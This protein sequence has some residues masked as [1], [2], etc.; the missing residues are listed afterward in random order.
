MRD[1]SASDA[2]VR[3]AWRGKY[4]AF[5]EP[6][7][8]GMKHLRA[9][10]RAGLTDVHLLPVFDFASVPERDCKQPAVPKA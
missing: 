8:R 10:A 5:T 1:F 6:A 4:L 9:L 3:P 7:S 2:S